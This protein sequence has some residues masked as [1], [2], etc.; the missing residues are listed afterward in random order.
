MAVSSQVGHP[1][2]VVK[3]QPGTEQSKG[4]GG[5]MVGSLLGLGVGPSLKVGESLPTRGHQEVW[6]PQCLCN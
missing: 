6:K 3:S 5:A 4:I 1:I 2:G